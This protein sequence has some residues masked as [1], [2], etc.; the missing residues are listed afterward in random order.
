MG[1]KFNDKSGAAGVA[2]WMNQYLS[3]AGGEQLDKKHP[4]VVEIAAWVEAQ[5]LQGRTTAIASEEMIE[6]IHERLPECA[7]P[8]GRSFSPGMPS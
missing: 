2:Y 5:Y 4:A 1:V 8:G 3:L 7:S 6:L